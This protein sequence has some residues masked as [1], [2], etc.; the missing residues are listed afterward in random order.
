MEAINTSIAFISFHRYESQHMFKKI[1]SRNP[2]GFKIATRAQRSHT[3]LS[4]FNQSFHKLGIDNTNILFSTNN[5]P[6]K[7]LKV[8]CL[9]PVLLLILYIVRF[10]G[11]YFIHN[12]HFP[13]SCFLGLRQMHFH[14]ITILPRYTIRIRFTDS[15]NRI[16]QYP[17][18]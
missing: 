4:R 15:I 7:R 16:L 18:H 17:Y 9:L 3:H 10:A 5:T 1:A 2:I 11:T 14:K 6:I 8:S 13:F 12:N